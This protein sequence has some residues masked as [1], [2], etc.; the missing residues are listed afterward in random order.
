MLFLS[1]LRP[2]GHLIFQ[3]AILQ[4]HREG[5]LLETLIPSPRTY[6]LTMDIFFAV[7]ALLRIKLPMQNLLKAVIVAIADVFAAL[8]AIRFL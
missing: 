2:D 4:S 1:L 5:I 3:A 8:L 7:A 6:R